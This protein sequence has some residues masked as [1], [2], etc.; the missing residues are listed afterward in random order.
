MCPRRLACFAFALLALSACDAPQPLRLGFIGGLSGANA[1]LGSAGRNGVQL[2]IEQ[3]NAQGGIRGR[4]IELLV[5]D[6]QLDPEQGQRVTQQLI[7]AQV[8]AILGPMTSAVAVA[9]APLATR[10]GLLMMAGTVTTQAL[11]GQDDQFF[12]TIGSTA[13]HAAI[14]ADYLYDERAIRQLNIAIDLRNRAYSESWL[15]DF[16]VHFESLGGRI[17]HVQSYTSGAQTDFAALARAA[18]HG[19]PQAL[20]L[21]TSALDAALL[22]NQLRQQQP[23]LLLAT[24]EWAGTGKL[25]ELGGHAV[26]EVVVPN[27]LDQQSQVPAFMAFRQAYR[28]RFQHDPGYPAVVTYNATQVVL[29]ALTD[30]RPGEALKQTLLRQRDYQGLLDPI[31]FDDF[32]DV[33]SRT[34]LTLI[35]HGEFI[36]AQ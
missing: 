8:E 33:R 22:C 15:N 28:Q 1:D 7:D 20:V 3:A 32:G 4:P 35:R 30:Q 27:Y 26:E 17:E 18:R 14:M 36:N 25:I 5:K 6:D 10:A 16:R 13:Q 21:I 12:R 31:H 34:Y 29:Q 19:Q 2:A 11:A 9:S 24:S 23:G